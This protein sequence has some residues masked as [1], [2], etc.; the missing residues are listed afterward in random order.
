M[1]VLSIASVNK[2]FGNLTSAASAMLDPFLPAEKLRSHIGE[3]AEASA[4][5]LD[6]MLKG[7][8]HILLVGCG[9]DFDEYCTP[10]VEMLTAKGAGFDIRC[11]W[12]ETTYNAT[13]EGGDITTII[14]DFSDGQGEDYDL[15]IIATSLLPS[16][17][18]I[19]A[20]V[21]R[22]RS[23]ETFQRLVVS[24]GI[25]A[26]DAELY[27]VD[28]EPNAIRFSAAS[29]LL[30][31]LKATPLP[32]A[33]FEQTLARNRRYFRHM[34]QSIEEILVGRQ[35]DLKTSLARSFPI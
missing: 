13:V 15:A 14:Q 21:S 34:P 12:P 28:Y 16:A 19:E 20:F 2:K 11:Y 32:Y 6:S 4:L 3:L 24:A 30:S 10:I 26:G 17:T 23:F 8:E 18:F 25:L 33:R 22:L 1:N 35:P 31:G 9:I 29:F 5:Q 7:T 27:L